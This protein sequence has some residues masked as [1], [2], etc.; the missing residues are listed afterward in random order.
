MVVDRKNP[1]K[2]RLFSFKMK[3]D[4]VI[5]KILLWYCHAQVRRTFYNFYFKCTIIKRVLQLCLFLIHYLI[6]VLKAV[7]ECT[8]CRIFKYQK[9]GSNLWHPACESDALSWDLTK[10]KEGTE[11]KGV[12]K[13]IW[14]RE[15]KKANMKKGGNI[16][17]PTP[18]QG[19][20]ILRNTN[21]VYS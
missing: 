2:T 3:G 7:T 4:L 17:A 18:I 5:N 21:S 13:I 11:E 14:E 6:Q 20:F 15:G 8:V 19:G 9:W 10:I 12:E 1:Q 16:E